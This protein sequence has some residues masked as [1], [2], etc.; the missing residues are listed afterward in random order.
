MNVIQR[1]DELCKENESDINADLTDTAKLVSVYSFYHYLNGD[2]SQLEDIASSLCY[3]DPQEW[4]F[5]SVYRSATID[6]SAVDFITTVNRTTLENLTESELKE[7]IQAGAKEIG[8]TVM[9]EKTAKHNVQMVYDT[10]GIRVADDDTV[11][12]TMKVLCDWV[13]DPEVKVWL[14]T[15]VSSCSVKNHMVGFEL[16]FADD[17]EQEIDDVESPKQYVSSGMLTTFGNSTVCEIGAE[18]SFITVVSA[19]SLKKMF[20]QYSTRG[21]F[22]SNLRFFISAKKIDPKIINSIHNDSE[23]FVY[24]NNGIIITCDS[25]VRAGDQLRFTNFSIVNG[26]QTT[27]LIGR[28]SFSEDFG[29]VCKVIVSRY[30]D[31]FEKVVFLSKVAEASN[32]QK[33]INA[34]DLIANRKEQRLLKEQFSRCG[35]FLK[36]KRGEKINK[37]LY[38]ES[39]QNASNDEVSQIIYSMVYQMPCSAKNSKAALLSNDNTYE[40]IF[41]STYSDQFFLS[42]QHLKVGYAK[43][44]KDLAKKESFGSNKLGMSKTGDLLT[45]SMVGLIMKLMTNDALLTQLMSYSSK[46]L[47]TDN[48]DVKFMI[49]QNDIGSLSLVEPSM[50]AYLNSQSFHRLFDFIFDFILVPAYRRFKKEYPNYSYSHLTKTQAYFTRFIFPTAVDCIIHRKAIIERD[51]SGILNLKADSSVGFRTKRL[52]DDYRPGLEQELKEFRERIARES[53]NAVTKA[54]VISLQ[55]ML[56]ICRVLPKNNIDLE[57]KCGFGRSQLELYGESILRIVAK[58][59]DVSGFDEGG[60]CDED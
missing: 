31:N 18:G 41:G 58:Y 20:F 36:V 9:H 4:S 43:W 54:R 51:F 1:F 50:I 8:A 33:P 44:K 6:G 47:E 55:Q 14:Q 46:E 59:S 34:K 7:H 17:V 35:I 49:Q 2:V 52:F 27:N 28:T 19:L 22:A 13:P 3:K 30:E 48:A 37:K 57:Y 60:N 38:P 11:Y 16:I 23:N 42:I 32:T 5:V 26:G 21:L 29:V 45:Y 24:Y 56:N 15:I 10:L 40:M 12:F 53:N 25:C 39:W